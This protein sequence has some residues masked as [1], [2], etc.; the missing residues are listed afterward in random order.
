MQ[1]QHLWNVAPCSF[2]DSSRQASARW[3][4]WARQARLTGARS[5]SEACGLFVGHLDQLVVQAPVARI[6]RDISVAVALIARA[7]G[8]LVA[9]QV[10]GNNARTNVQSD[11]WV[12]SSEAIAAQR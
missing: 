1:E 11:R 5:A 10:T 9:L 7:G 6:E 8:I 12:Y 3:R 2:Q 4:M